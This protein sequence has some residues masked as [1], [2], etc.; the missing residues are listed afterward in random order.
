[1]PFVAAEFRPTSVLKETS[2]KFYGD[3]VVISLVEAKST[4][5]SVEPAETLPLVVSQEDRL[6]EVL[7]SSYLNGDF[8]DDGPTAYLE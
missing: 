2:F 1:M 3:L 8:L 6:E 5:Q 4:E 7:H